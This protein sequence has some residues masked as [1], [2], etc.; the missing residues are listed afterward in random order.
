MACTGWCCGVVA[1]NVIC[2]PFRIIWH[3]FW[4]AW[5]GVLQPILK[6]LLVCLFWPRGSVAW[7]FWR[8]V[9]CSM[10]LDE[11]STGIKDKVTM[12]CNT[13]QC[14]STRL[15][16]LLCACDAAQRYQSYSQLA[17]QGLRLVS[18]LGRQ[19]CI[20]ADAWMSFR[21]PMVWHHTGMAASD[22]SSSQLQPYR[23]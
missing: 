6:L 2:R 15:V 12:H 17:L 11:A 19:T 3:L 14:C 13:P 22:T 18:L 20:S 9:F 1:V 5:Y 23:L 16:L 21:A 10:W 4:F 7:D 8:K